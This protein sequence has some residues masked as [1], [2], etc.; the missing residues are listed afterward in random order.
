[1]DKQTTRL[2]DRQTCMKGG[3]MSGQMNSLVDEHMDGKAVRRTEVY[4]LKDG[5][6][7]P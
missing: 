1:M 2:T 5:Q 7:R 6:A 3:K 4:E